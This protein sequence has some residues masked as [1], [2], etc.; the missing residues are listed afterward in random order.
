MLNG[1][2][3]ITLVTINKAVKEFFKILISQE[4]PKECQNVQNFGFD[5]KPAK[6]SKGLMISTASGKTN[7]IVGYILQS[8]KTEIGESRMYATD[9]SGTDIGD[10]KLNSDGEFVILD[11][12]DYATKYNSLKSDIAAF[13][14]LLTD[15][16]ALIATGIT[17]AGG[18]Y[19][20]TGLSIDISNGTKAD[21]V[22]I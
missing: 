21:K 15:E 17:G 1:H 12:S 4:D 6:G 19:T 5:S 20:P 10:V 18:A 2:N 9:S 3:M 11:G 22:R 8:D 13:N 7:T 16:L 14:I